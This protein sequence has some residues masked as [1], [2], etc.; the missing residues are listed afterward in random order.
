MNLILEVS[1]LATS[2]YKLFI[3]QLLIKATYCCYV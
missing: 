3:S 1:Y 2:E